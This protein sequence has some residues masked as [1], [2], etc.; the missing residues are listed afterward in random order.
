MPREKKQAYGPI[1]PQPQEELTVVVMKYK[2]GSQSLQKG[3]D[4][5]SQAIAA[6][7]PAPQNNHGVF[8]QR[9]PAQLHPA[10]E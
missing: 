1:Q 5:V 6:L 2:G 4:A 9:Q 7:G 8:V 3:F 10:A